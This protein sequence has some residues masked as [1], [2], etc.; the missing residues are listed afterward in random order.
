MELN[1]KLQKL[2][3]QRGLTQE[4]LA[5]ALY[6]SRTA[7]SKWESGRGYPSIDS[8]KAIASFFSVTI[9]ELLNEEEIP[10]AAECEPGK[11]KRCDPGLGLLDCGAAAFLFL[12]LFGQSAG[13]SVQEVSLLALTGAPLYLRI[14]Y[15]AIVAAMIALGI[16]MLAL[17]NSTSAF[18]TRN[19]VR[20]SLAVSALAVLLFIMGRQS[21]AAASAFIFLA[22][23]G[24][25]LLK[26]ALTRS[27]SPM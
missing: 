15:F 26:T 27:V 22:I 11:E 13:G 19:K 5:E 23:K 1:E 21:Y 25:L 18:W 9:D 12:P 6:V 24:F 16:L 3:K 14:V 7:I 8:L 4:E 10:D 17:Q 2:R 20:L